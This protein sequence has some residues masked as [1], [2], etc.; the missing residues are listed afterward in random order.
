MYKSLL[1]AGAHNGKLSRWSSDAATGDD[2]TSSAVGQPW[3]AS[4]LCDAGP[5]AGS[6]GV[7]LGKALWTHTRAARLWPRRASAQQT[8]SDICRWFSHSSLHSCAIR[9]A[10]QNALTLPQTLPHGS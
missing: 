10:E 6:L 3:L 2:D 8:P 9:P 5:G 4:N 7:G 1:Q